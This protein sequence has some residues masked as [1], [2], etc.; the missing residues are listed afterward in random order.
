MKEIEFRVAREC[1]LSGAEAIIERVCA[2]SGLVVGMKGS[3]ASYPGSVH[4]HYKKQ[5]QK[6]TLELTLYR[7]ESRIWAQVQ[8]GRRAA[9]I[10]VELPRLRRAI[11]RGLRGNTSHGR[12]ALKA[13]R[14]AGKH[15]RA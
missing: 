7:K 8:D 11:E 9:W 15:E 4:W 3:L 1:G 5:N 14:P 10:D 2:E 13:K 12:K 6:G